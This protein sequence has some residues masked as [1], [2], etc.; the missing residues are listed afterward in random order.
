MEVISYALFSAAYTQSVEADLPY[1]AHVIL[2]EVRRIH[3]RNR[4]IHI[5]RCLKRVWY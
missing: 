5:A 3:C 2:S 1:E 4:L